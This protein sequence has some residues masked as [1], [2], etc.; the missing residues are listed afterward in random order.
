MATRI[1]VAAHQVW[2]RNADGTE[3]PM[4]YDRLV[5]GTGAVPVRPAIDGLAGP[6]ALGAADGAHLLHT[7]GDTF[8]LQ[9]SLDELRPTSAL[10]VGAGY[11]GLEMA[12]GLTVRGLAVSRSKRCPKSSPTSTPNWALVRAELEARGVQVSTSTTVRGVARAPVGTS[13]RLVVE[14]TDGGD[15]TFSRSADLVL[16]RRGAP[17][18][19]AVAQCRGH[20]RSSG[21]RR[22]RRADANRATRCIRRRGLRGDPPPPPRR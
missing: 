20:D 17:R 6:S 8:A 5:V 12:D 10:I 21:C 9:R 14:G 16:V 4:T 3:E 19:G 7:M 1:D 2:L 11:V 22:C 18:H 15:R 13:G